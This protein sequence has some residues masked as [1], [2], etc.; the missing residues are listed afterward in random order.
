MVEFQQEGKAV[1][2][3]TK[4]RS[5]YQGNNIEDYNQTFKMAC[6]GSK[7]VMDRKD[8]GRTKRSAKDSA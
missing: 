5:K 7:T 1:G 3:L 8:M 6:D 2:N 4:R